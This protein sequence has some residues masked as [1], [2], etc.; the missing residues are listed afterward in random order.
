MST[1]RHKLIDVG[2]FSR[3][4]QVEAL[5]GVLG[6]LLEGFLVVLVI[7]LQQNIAERMPVSLLDRFERAL[8]SKTAESF[9]QALCR[10]DQLFFRNVAVFLNK[11][12]DSA[13]AIR[14]HI[15]HGSGRHLLPK[16]GRNDRLANHLAF[17]LNP[18]GALRV[19]H[20]PLGEKIVLKL[21]D[22]WLRLRGH[23]AEYASTV[24]SQRLQVNDLFSMFS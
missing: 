4:F 9:F 19:D 24:A 6:T 14:L 22:G 7:V 2:G 16:C 10:V 11:E 5:Y 21:L 1:G 3:C 13:F 15:K 23:P 18:N 20:P 8:Q 17:T 12:L